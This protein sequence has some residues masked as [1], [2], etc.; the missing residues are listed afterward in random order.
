MALV[1]GFSTYPPPFKHTEVSSGIYEL[2]APK[3]ALF[4]F[5][6]RCPSS[7]RRPPYFRFR[8]HLLL[9]GF[10]GSGS[11]WY[12]CGPPYG[13]FISSFSV[14]LPHCKL[15]RESLVTCNLPLT[16][17]VFPHSGHHRLSP[18]PPAPEAFGTSATCMPARVSS[19][20][21]CICRMAARRLYS[22]HTG[23]KGGRGRK[24]N[25]LC[26]VINRRGSPTETVESVASS[27]PT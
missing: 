23:A 25:D 17:A 13:S 6:L 5:L 1:S 15:V 22:L 20:G 21:W 19:W 10:S 9:P 16:L 27:S 14:L 26:H 7:V 18:S 2:S 8:S 3:S 4:G 24:R 11:R 12:D